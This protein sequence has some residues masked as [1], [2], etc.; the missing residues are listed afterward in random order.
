MSYNTTS[1]ICDGAHKPFPESTGYVQIGNQF[2]SGLAIKTKIR[3]NSFKKG[4]Q[5][6]HTDSMSCCFIATQ[7]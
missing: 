4:T 2:F 7:M 3:L 6:N 1:C 5:Q